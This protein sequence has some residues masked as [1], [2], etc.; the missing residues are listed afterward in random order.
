M[1]MMQARIKEV[2]IG[3]IDNKSKPWRML[4]AMSAEVARAIIKKATSR[5]EPLVNLEELGSVN[6]ISVQ[7]EKVMKEEMRSLR[8]MIV[9]DMDNTLLQGRFIILQKSNIQSISGLKR[10]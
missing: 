10:D 9:F 2:N 4:G 7:M 1:F 5:K 3:Y 8:K 6:E